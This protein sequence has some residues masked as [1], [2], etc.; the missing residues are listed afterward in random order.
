MGL[1]P[2]TPIESQQISSTWPEQHP[3][4]GIQPPLDAI[5][6]VDGR[7][8][9]AIEADYKTNDITAFAML[10]HQ[11]TITQQGYVISFDFYYTM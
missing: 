5:R 10:R 1:Q 8:P 3:Y 7:A 11:I 4:N 6:L 9:L 2:N